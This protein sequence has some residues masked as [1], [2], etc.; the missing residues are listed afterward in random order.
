MF[1]KYFV[2]S[3]C[4]CFSLILTNFCLYS[5]EIQSES[6]SQKF[7]NFLQGFDIFPGDRHGDFEGDLLAIL[8]DGSA[9]KIHPDDQEKASNWELGDFVH[10]SV[11]T[12]FYWFKREHKF[13]LCNH[14]RGEALK[15]MIIRHAQPPLQ[16]L[17]TSDTYPTNMIEVEEYV[18]NDRLGNP[19]F[20]E[21]I[22]PADFKKE[23]TLNDGTSWIIG[24]KFEDFSPETF[25]YMGEK[26]TEEGIDKFLICGTEREAVWTWIK[27]HSVSDEN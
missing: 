13:L 11:R 17:A 12:S 20:E 5:S 2:C 26:E 7:S 16:I 27:P 24:E 19:I 21:E 1:L 6:T 14:N 8:S 23:I 4:A 22:I 10:I 9:W 25:V 18:A 15:V 3:C